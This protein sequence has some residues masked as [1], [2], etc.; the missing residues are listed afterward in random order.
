[1]AEFFLKFE[2]LAD[3]AGVDLDRYPNATLYVKKNIQRVLIDQL[4]Q[5]DNPPTTYR[6]YK[7]RIVIMD[8]MRRRRD[9]HNTPR[10]TNSLCQKDSSTMEVDRSLKKETRKC[11]ACRKEGHLARGCPEKKTGF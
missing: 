6:D 8:E 3:I 11:F 4:Y 9:S 2:E 5:S 1:V 10:Q 7:R